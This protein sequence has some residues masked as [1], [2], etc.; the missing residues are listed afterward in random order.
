MR[1][2]APPSEDVISRARALSVDLTGPVGAQLER[3]LTLLFAAN[4]QFNLT[5]V[6][7]VEEAWSRHVLDSLS[8]LPW[9]SDLP[10]GSRLI[11]VGAGGGLPGIPI[12]IARP[13]LAI[14]LL[15]ATGKKAAFIA[16][17][18]AALSLA[19]VTV[20]NERAETAGQS[21]A[22]E[23]FDVATARALSR[24]PTLLELTLPFVR[25]GGYLLA[26]K[27]EQAARE[28]E[29]AQKALSVLGGHVATLRRGETGT[30][31]RIDK[32]RPTPARYPRR[33]GEPKR[34]PLR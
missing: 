8:L 22:R 16:D 4:A 33:P 21:R 31:V 28:V 32:A 27:G 18:A 12:A 19:N 26:I 2:V 34:V 1:A 24:L 5:A 25:V 20:L 9:L 7:T 10:S 23:S 6:T 13:D 14:T 11:D 17:A 3:F 15:E 30:V 29:E